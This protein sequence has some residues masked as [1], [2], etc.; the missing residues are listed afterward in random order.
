MKPGTNE[1]C[2]P[3]EVGEVCLKG[4]G[5][6]THFLNRPDET[7]EYFDEEGF[8]HMGDLCKYTADGQLI[9]V[10]RMK[11]MIK[12]EQKIHINNLSLLI[13]EQFQVQWQSCGPDRIGRDFAKAS[14]RL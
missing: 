4:P 14:S 11:E 1:R 12:Y 9:Y 2:G 5:L 3:E 8:G 10:D 7:K 6:M 13:F